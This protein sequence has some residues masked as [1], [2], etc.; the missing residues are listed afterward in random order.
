M[1]KDKKKTTLKKNKVSIIILT[2]NALKM[3]T[4]QLQDVSKLDT[5]GLISETIVVDNGS[6]DGT[7]EKLSKYKLPNMNYKFIKTGKNLGYAGGINYGIKDAM[8]RGA[9]YVI[10]MNNDLI[11]QKDL[12]TRLVDLAKKNETIGLISPKMYFARGFEFH[13]KILTPEGVK[14][15]YTENEKGKIIWYAGGI[16]DK[17]NVYSL[18]RGVDEVDINQYEETEDTDFINGACVLITK[19]VLDKVG[20]LDETFFLYWEDADYSMKVKRAGFRVVYTPETKIWHMV[21]VSAGKSGSFSN[22]YFLTRNR[23][24]FAMR[25]AKLRTKFA[26]IK[27]TLRLIFIGRTWQKWGAIDAILGRKGQGQ[28]KY[29]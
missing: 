19:D 4:K 10:L 20:L 14:N 12:L 11:L 27:D 13:K 29:R 9:D 25:Y 24:F 16:L 26:I 3:T 28:W 18:H 7:I 21:S 23:F 1:A 2:W 17:E 22:D 8:K 5:T 6:I 15:R